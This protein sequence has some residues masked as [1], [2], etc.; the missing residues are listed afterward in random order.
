MMT[1][2]F[3]LHQVRICLLAFLVGFVLLSPVCAI[4][5]ETQERDGDVVKVVPMKR[6]PVELG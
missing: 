3:K 2:Q 1:S 5:Q 6:V 4:A